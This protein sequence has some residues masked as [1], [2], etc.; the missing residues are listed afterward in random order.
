MTKQSLFLIQMGIDQPFWLDAYN[1]G[2]EFE[3]TR[4]QKTAWRF[5]LDEAERMLTRV[6]AI[7]PDALLLEA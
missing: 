5:R 6:Q 4:E 3:W 7:L 1:G 2:V